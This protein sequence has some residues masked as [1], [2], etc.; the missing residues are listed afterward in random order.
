MKI[1]IVIQSDDFRDSAGMRI[2]YDR[3]R[4]SLDS[5]EVTIEAA[6]IAELAAAKTLDHDV[7][8]FCKTFDI[9]ALLLARRV[10]AAGKAVG[11]DLFDDYFSQHSDSR[12]QRYRD[13]LRDMA[14]VTDF[15]I[16]ST[17]QMAEVV[18][19]YLP[20]LPIT[21]IDDPV[22]GFEPAAVAALAEQKVEQARS[23]RSI[24]LLWFGIGD[25]PFFPVGLTDLAACEGE[26]ATMQRLGWTVRLR[27]LTNRRPFEGAGGE[28]LRRFGLGFELIEWSEER[29]RE[30]LAAASVAIIPVN[31]QAFSRAKSLNRA[32]TALAAGCQVLN[33]GYPL[34]ERLGEFVYRSTEQLLD[35]LSAGRCR[36][37][38]ASIDELAATLAVLADPSKAASSFVAEAQ[39]ALERLSFRKRAAGPVCLLHGRA[40]PIAAHKAVGAIGGYSVKTIFCKAGWN[41]PIRFESE[42]GEIVMRLTPQ[43]AE[44]FGVPLRDAGARRLG[45]FDLVLADTEGMG[46]PALRITLSDCSNP[47]LDLVIYEDVMR[48]AQQCCAAAFPGA[49]IL[50][51][52]TSIFARR[53]VTPVLPRPRKGRT[54]ASR[55]APKRQPWSPI[56]KM[57]KSRS[58]PKAEAG[59]AAAALL[60]KSSLFD[61]QWYLARYPDV[62]S[63][64]MDPLRHY[65]EFGWREG[66]DP[67]P[68][69]ST[70][71]YLKANKDVAARGVN[72]LLHYLE[73]GQA[74]GRSAPRAARGAT[75]P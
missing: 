75:S 70:K 3:F 8:V 62:S 58:R 51:S 46:V 56:G 63:S 69:F 72:P 19:P 20:D 29:E 66:R 52:D 33:P 15:A 13:W 27:I 64:G 17:P 2:R 9:A 7:Y 68:R 25:N 41:F 73:Y 18:R 23:T 40:S 30:E 34:Y 35:D 61:A 11:Q 44:K 43:I 37:G 71:G 67:G 53:P 38:A 36:L 10:R 45:I 47:V 14:T 49:D 4:D 32:V 55:L 22:I 21:A 24:D 1:C 54:A 50:I 5:A 39:A 42:H 28:V 16:C 57:L 59:R 74:E 65:L 26:L 12:L 60:R 48:F 6:T 31:G